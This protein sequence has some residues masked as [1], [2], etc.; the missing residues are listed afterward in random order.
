MSQD[1]FTNENLGINLNQV[2]GWLD[3]YYY[4]LDFY[5]REQMPLMINKEYMTKAQFHVEE[6]RGGYFAPESGTSES[7]FLTIKG[8][9]EVYEITRDIK[10][11]NKAIEMADST[12]DVL[13]RGKEAPDEFNEDDLWLPHWLY[14][15]SE[16]FT[17]EAFYLDKVVSF[18]NGV[19]TFRA[20]FEAREVYTARA[21]DAELKWANPYSEIL[22][23]TY[24]I[25]SYTLDGKDITITLKENFTGNLKVVYADFGG[26]I[27]EPNEPYEAWPLWR[28]LEDTEIACAIDSLWWAYDSF[29]LLN[30]HTSDPKWE[31]ALNNLRETIPYALDVVNLGDYLTTDRT[32][33]DP[34]SAP[35]SY[36][37]QEKDSEE[38]TSRSEAKISRS[39][40]T[41]A[42]VVDIPYGEGYVQLGRAYLET[43][44]SED[45]A[46]KVKIKSNR[47]NLLEFILQTEKEYSESSRYTARFRLKTSSNPREFT[48]SRTDFIQKQHLLWDIFYKDGSIWET[49]QSYNSSTKFTIVEEDKRDTAKIE[50]KRGTERD[51]NGYEYTGWSQ[52]LPMFEGSNKLSSIPPFRY[53]LDGEIQLKITDRNNAEWFC[54]IPRSAGY[55]TL[56]LTPSDF[57]SRGTAS[58]VFPLKQVLFDAVSKKATLHLQYLGKA[59]S[60]PLGSTIREA[61]LNITD[62]S[63]QKLELFY[64]RP[65][66]AETYTYVPY[67]APFTINLLD[68][69]I[70]D[71]R[72]SAYTGYQAPW[73][74][75]ELDTPEGL[76]A[77][78]DFMERAQLEYEEET[79]VK[80][81]FMPVFLWD[82]WDSREYGKANTFTWE[83]ADPNTH[84]G[85][86]QYRAIETVARAWFND[87]SN[88][89]ARRITMRFIESINTLWKSENDFIITDFP[90]GQVPVGE[91][92]EP[93]MAALLLR[94]AIFGYKASTNEFEKATLLSVIQKCIKYMERLFRGFDKPVEWNNNFLNGTWSIDQASWYNFWGG[95]I[96]SGLAL[97]LKY[98]KTTINMQTQYGK[99]EVET[100]PDIDDSITKSIKVKTPIGIQKVKLVDHTS[101]EAT[102][103]MVKTKEGNMAIGGIR[104]LDNNIKIL[105]NNQG[106]AMKKIDVLE[107][108]MVFPN[109]EDGMIKI[110]SIKGKTITN[111]SPRASYDYSVNNWVNLFTLE[112]DKDYTLS[113]KITSPDDTVFTL[114]FRDEEGADFGW[115]N[116]G[117]AS[118]AESIY[119]GFTT[120]SNARG[121]MLY[122]QDAGANV[123]ITDI[124]LING[125]YSNVPSPSY[126]ENEASAGEI[127]DNASFTIEVEK[128]TQ[129]VQLNLLDIVPEDKLPLRSNGAVA[130]EIVG[131]VLYK[132]IGN[133]GTVLSTPETIVL[134][135][136][137]TVLES[138]KGAKI[139]I[140]EPNS[141]FPEL[142][143]EYPLPMAEYIQEFIQ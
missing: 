75:Q 17:A 100:Y 105:I 61:L 37:Y 121:A 142:D 53:K 16:P 82:R 122:L 63:R 135:K 138:F 30:K 104:E 18:S 66:P 57:T 21:M 42:I 109:I 28:K 139:A 110:N 125:L 11:L 86:F 7:Q 132:R 87:P 65:L 133:D 67:V 99:V 114:V 80:G 9:L 127:V 98:S 128:D 59:V 126:F 70:N 97:L 60:I 119:F 91:Y 136:T 10:W 52:F 1:Y 89:Q 41:G 34:L 32:N 19:G 20:D 26:E 12:I 48:F 31:R 102:P 5:T 27:I 39:E 44:V 78:L 6:G 76:K 124:M 141:V 72:G 140:R 24:E 92:N 83:G 29:Y 93:H 54:T 45:R 115:T 3:D 2:G 107:H 43:I 36:I 106:N 101:P 137:I 50:F 55:R 112:P 38:G 64:I 74:W 40:S 4:F 111:Y 62:T 103:F 73:I 47:T 85:G 131:N 123:Q 14:N 56:T 33:T 79:K 90:E 113:F 143:I 117:S 81:F 130:D 58:M 69:K 77:V 94:G 22:G 95:E 23:K 25:D 13:Y 120:A 49:Y 8:F 51:E 46:F 35:D 129:R 71:W 108:E 118:E 134:K 68:S 116:I 96:L 88:Q 84:W 15:A